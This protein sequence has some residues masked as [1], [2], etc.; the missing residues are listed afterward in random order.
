M[1]AGLAELGAYFGE[2]PGV[3]V[4]SGVELPLP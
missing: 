4:F 3:T 2:A 1:H